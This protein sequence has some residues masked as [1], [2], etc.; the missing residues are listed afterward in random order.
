MIEHLEVLDQ[1]FMVDP[2][3]LTY[4][5][6]AKLLHCGIA[7]LTQYHSEN[8]PSYKNILSSVDYRVET[9]YNLSDFPSIPVRLFKEIGLVTNPKNVSIRSLNSSGTSDQ[10]TSKI[11]IDAETSSLQTKALIKIISHYIG[12]QRLPMLVIDAPSTT[13]N[14]SIFTARAAGILG[15]SRFST[16]I[17]YALNDDMSPNW[18]AIL[19]FT[20]SNGSN[21]VL[22]FGFTSLVWIHLIKQMESAN[23]NLELS[24]ATFFHGGGWKKI[25]EED[26]VTKEDF[27]NNIKRILGTTK[28]HDYYGMAEQ[29]GSIMVECEYGYMHTSIY[30]EIFIRN[31]LTHE[32][33]GL[34]ETGLVE[35][36]SILPRSYPG[37]VL[38]TED[39]A[40]QIGVDDCSCGKLGSYFLIEG[41][42]KRAEIRGCSDT[43]QID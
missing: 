20:N 27:K 21:P 15:F 43:Y 9:I 36:I 22:I 34:N 3:S 7:Q 1:M 4:N 32:I 26:Q 23:I 18:E 42:V 40:R 29:T 5:E 10:L 31:Q 8:N 41:R 37:H 24:G 35:T 6:K 11:Y 39:L 13:K 12:K 17:T 33:N 25:A 38:L 28:V 30:S 2:Y 19:E 16:S 14:R